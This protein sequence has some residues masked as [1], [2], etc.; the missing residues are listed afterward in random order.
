[1]GSEKLLPSVKGGEGDLKHLADLF[2]GPDMEEMFCEHTEYEKQA[3]LPVRNYRV[4]KDGMRSPAGADDPEDPDPCHNRP[5]IHE[6]DQPAV[7]IPMDTAV[8]FA[9]TVRAGLLFR[10]EM[11]HIFAQEQFSRLFFTNKLAI[12]QIFS[13]HSKCIESHAIS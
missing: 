5:A 9:L 8:S 11:W 2:Y 13:Y 4:K 1:V 10:A 7:I 12:D 3:M 6:V